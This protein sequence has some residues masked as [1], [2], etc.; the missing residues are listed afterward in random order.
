MQFS[1]IIPVYNIKQYILECLNSIVCQK[2]SD[3]EVLLIDDG[4]T[5]GS[6]TICDDF[7]KRDPRFKVVH[8]KN[9]GPSVARNRGIEDAQG[10]FILFMD[11][12]DYWAKDMFLS[13]LSE[14]IHRHN[15]DIVAYGGNSLLVKGDKRFLTDE[16]MNI[17]CQEGIFTVKEFLEINLKG[18]KCYSW[19]PW[20]YAYRRK[21]FA[22]TLLRFP[23]GRKYEDVYLT[24][25]ILIKATGIGIL[26]DKYYVYRKERS[27]STTTAKSY[28][29]L[30]DFLWVIQKNLYDINHMAMDEEMKGLLT[31]NFSKGYFT[32]C[33][34]AGFL[35]IRH[36][37]R[38]IKKLK[39][40]RYVMNYSTTT[41]YV[42]IVRIS[43]I[44]GI[45]G[46]VLLLG[47]RR[48]I[49]GICGMNDHESENCG[50]ICIMGKK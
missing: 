50:G 42:I 39:K 48:R 37:N 29:S 32:C 34:F 35:D 19:Y 14:Y 12:D 46:L 36:R 20:L 18:N 2:Y 13:D 44:I 16:S 25:R 27:G 24:W 7:A 10:D 45:K 47:L 41:P 38:Y 28:Q 3:Y 26:E 15:T 11:G 8:E 5:D 30:C 43:K 9:A 4:S 21:L 1:I 49:K 17:L 23:V 40:A 31:D 6:E 33:I 22:D